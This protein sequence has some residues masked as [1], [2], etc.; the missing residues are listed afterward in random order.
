MSS[1]SNLAFEDWYTWTCMWNRTFKDWRVLILLL[2]YGQCMLMR[3]AV[4]FKRLYIVFDG[5]NLSYQSET[6][7]EIER[8]RFCV[9]CAAWQVTLT[10][11][12]GAPSFSCMR[13][14]HFQSM[15]AGQLCLLFVVED[16]S[17]PSLEAYRLFAN[18]CN[19]D[20]ALQIRRIISPQPR[21]YRKNC[22]HQKNCTAATTTTT[23][24]TRTTTTTTTRTTTTTTTTVTYLRIP[25]V[26]RCCGS[27]L[28]F[29]YYSP[30]CWCSFTGDD[31]AWEP[32]QFFERFG[33]IGYPAH[34][35]HCHRTLLHCRG[36]YRWGRTEEHW[37]SISGKLQCHKIKRPR[38]WPCLSLH[39]FNHW[40]L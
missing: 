28:D 13:V 36:A 4:W 40:Q 17:V 21:H 9:P 30:E 32:L 22:H 12:E 38:N 3:L 14:P 16:D 2:G 26:F 27:T 31:T 15:S 8:L 34:T 37:N 29:E 1:V 19:M 11:F 10:S 35:F 24:T 33:L 23:T 25:P 39:H 18:V 5:I 6:M 7:H 20:S